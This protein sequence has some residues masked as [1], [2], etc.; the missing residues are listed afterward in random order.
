M[1]AGARLLVNWCTAL[2]PGH[3]AGPPEV[4]AAPGTPGALAGRTGSYCMPSR[5]VFRP[6]PEQTVAELKPRVDCP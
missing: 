3:A 6:S 2:H 4:A 5:H 1:L